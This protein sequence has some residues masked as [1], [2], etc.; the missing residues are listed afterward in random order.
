MITFAEFI[1]F[2]LELEMVLDSGE[3]DSQDGVEE[4]DEGTDPE[5]AGLLR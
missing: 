5:L 2:L 4:G 1:V 3:V